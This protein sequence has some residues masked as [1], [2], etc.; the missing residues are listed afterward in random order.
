MSGRHNA[1]VPL[2]FVE[3]IGVPHS[4]SSAPRMVVFRQT[5]ADRYQ[6]AEGGKKFY[7]A[8]VRLV[9]GRGGGETPPDPIALCPQDFADLK[10]KRGINR[11]RG[12][13]S[14][15]EATETTEAPV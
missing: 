5:T 13:K 3:N 6:L 12:K 15:N 9:S 8:D 14:R 2:I 10:F 1:V 11:R 7:E 4:D